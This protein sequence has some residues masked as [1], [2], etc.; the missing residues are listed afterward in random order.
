MSSAIMKTG[1][2]TLE[3]FSAGVTGG[4][5]TK[6]N[7]KPDRHRVTAFRVRGFNELTDAL[8]MR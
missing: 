5:P 2:C 3:F 7:L 6:A 4:R 1:F 8:R